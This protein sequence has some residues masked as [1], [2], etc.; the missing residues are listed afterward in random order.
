MPT[1]ISNNRLVDEIRLIRAEREQRFRR[2]M[3]EI[4]R[5]YDREIARLYPPDRLSIAVISLCV[6]I[7]FV[8]LAAAG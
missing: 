1:T 3:E 8:F 4:D 6:A 5:Q 7:G 2:D